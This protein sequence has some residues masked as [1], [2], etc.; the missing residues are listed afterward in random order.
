[1]KELDRLNRFLSGVIL[2]YMIAILALVTL[3]T[4]SL[5]IFFRGNR[6]TFRAFF[7]HSKLNRAD[8]PLYCAIFLRKKPQIFVY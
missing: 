3:T 4:I 5:T 8:K 7:I 6:T 1:M 2:E